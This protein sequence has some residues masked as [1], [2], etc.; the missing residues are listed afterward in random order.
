MDDCMGPLPSDLLHA[1]PMMCSCCAFSLCLF[2]AASAAQSHN[3]L[4]QAVRA[5][6][7]KAA[8]A[9]S[10]GPFSCCACLKPVRTHLNVFATALVH[11]KAQQQPVERVHA[12]KGG[13]AVVLA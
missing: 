1:D 5:G 3:L 9:S 10:T 6:Y 2:F 11:L 4:N 8:V 12:Q 13:L 7:K